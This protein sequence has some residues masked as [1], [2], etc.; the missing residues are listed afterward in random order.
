MYRQLVREPVTTEMQAEVRRFYHDEFEPALAKHSA[1]E[2]PEDSFLPATSTGWYLHYHY[3]ATGAKPYGPKRISSA[4]DLS[5]YG[6]AVARALPGLQGAVDRFGHEGLLLVDAETLDVFFALQQSSILG[7]NL[8]NGPY[9]SS[10]LSGLVKSLRNSQNVDDYRVADF[11]AYQP[12]L[13]DP[14]AFVGTP[15]FEGP[16]M[17]AI[18]VLRLPIEPVSKALSGNRQWQAEGLGKTGEVYLLGPDQTMRTDSRFLDEDR[19]AFLQT[20]RRSILTSHAVDRVDRLGTTI[21][22]VPV[23]HEAA[24]AALRGE[25]GVKE[26]N[27]YRGV[28]VLMAY[29]PVDLDLLRWAVI[30]KMDVAEAMA[31]LGTTQSVWSHGAWASRS[32][33]R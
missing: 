16:R 21:L 23:T 4:T 17:I 22:T 7:T 33:P 28:P 26:L 24:V 10:N 15:V 30:A 32:S 1:I 14:M 31:P 6:L 13:G 25:T 2:P 29:G 8:L 9:A 3:V 27:D 20:L 19:T 18:M 5:A 12:S 11:E